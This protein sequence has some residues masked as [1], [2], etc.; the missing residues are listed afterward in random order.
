MCCDCCLTVACIEAHEYRSDEPSEYR[1]EEPWVWFRW[2]TPFFFHGQAHIAHHDRRKR[3]RTFEHLLLLLFCSQKKHASMRP[4][5]VCDKCAL[6][7][8][9]RICY[10][11]GSGSTRSCEPAPSVQNPPNPMHTLLTI[12]LEIN[13]CMRACV[14]VGR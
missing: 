14:C 1:S 8:H 12:W 3:L 6:R 5:C 11:P 13:A 7:R 9:R 4:R 2:T 10:I